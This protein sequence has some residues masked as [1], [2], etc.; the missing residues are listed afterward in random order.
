MH[1]QRLFSKCSTFGASGCAR[2]AA[3]IAVLALVASAGAQQRRCFVA[4]L[5]PGQ[6]TPP[7]VG[8][9][10]FGCAV[11][12]VDIPTSTVSYRVSFTGLTGAEAAAHIHGAAGPGVPAGV[13][14]ALPLGNPKVGSFVAAPPV[15]NAILS[16][17]AYFNLHSAGFP[18]GEIRG[19]IV[20]AVA[21]IDG[22]QE[23]PAVAT[24]ATGFGLFM[25]D[26]T[27]NTL[28]YYIAYGGLVGAET[29]AHIH[30]L[31]LHTAP[32]GVLVPLPAGNPKI[33]VWNYP[34]AL[35]RQ[36]C[37]GMTYV[38]IHTNAFP[39]GEIR[40]QIVTT[41]APMD[42]QQEVPPVP[43]TTGAG[44]GL[45]SFDEATNTMGY[46]IAFANMSSAETVRH[47]HGFA[48]PGAPAGVLVALP[49]GPR[50][51]G[52][53]IYGAANAA[54]VLA[55][56]TYINIHSVMFGGGELRGQIAPWPWTPPPC[57]GGR[58]DANC[59]GTLDFFDIDPFLL[60]LFDQP[61]YITTFCG[62]NLC[63]A[64]A[65]C[66]GT[67]DFFDIDA[68]LDCLFVGCPPCP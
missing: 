27:A 51:L 15:L 62:G 17:N 20:S 35:E 4:L 1:T 64:D 23:T 61:A 8:S 59:D 10:A 11:V 52:Q 13:L 21:R 63:A 36:I 57:P 45:I 5:T 30:G 24:P 55:G 25:I 39:N 46:D 53:W 31:A 42:A 58:G 50:K 68:L 33:G 37:A 9:N 3:A 7:V 38:N 16:G 26:T 12:I 65:N 40:G 60:A 67:V 6:E 34:Q 56:L 66:D 54:N 44:C 18:N 22:Q 43:I 14:V 29:A 48:P 2:F 47:I 49:A 19:Q 32:A 28:T 41:V